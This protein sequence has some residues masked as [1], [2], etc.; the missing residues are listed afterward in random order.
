[1]QALP[2]PWGLFPSLDKETTGELRKQFEKSSFSQAA[3]WIKACLGFHQETC[4]GISE[5]SLPTRVLDVGE[6]SID[7]R[8]VETN[9]RFG[10]YTSLSHCWGGKQPLTTTRDNFQKHLVSIPWETIPTTFQE[11]IKFNWYLGIQYL[12]IDSLCII[13]Q[14]SE[15]WARESAK[16]CQV[17]E[18]SYVTIAASSAFNSTQGLFLQDTWDLLS[19]QIS[20]A[21]AQDVEFFGRR[22]SPDHPRMQTAPGQEG[23]E[24]WP[25]FERAWVLQER[26]MSPRVV[27]FFKH[28]VAWECGR[29]TLCQCS[30]IRPTGKSEYRQT[31]LQSSS[32]AICAQWRQLVEIYSC[33]KLSFLSD[34]LPALSGLAKQMTRKRPG[35]RYLAGVWSDSLEMDLLWTRWR[36]P[37]MLSGIDGASAIRRAPSWSWVAIDARVNFLNESTVRLKWVYSRILDITT[38]LETADP[39]GRVSGGELTISGQFFDA[40]VCHRTISAERRV[41]DLPLETVEFGL[42]IAGT[43]KTVWEVSEDH[44]NEDALFFDFAMDPF[45]CG[46]GFVQPVESV[47]ILRMARIRHWSDGYQIPRGYGNLVQVDEA[48]YALILQRVETTETYRRV[49]ML[50]QRRVRRI[51]EA[52]YI[53]GDVGLWQD[54]PNAFEGL[55]IWDTVKIV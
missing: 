26:L 24:D 15:D 36:R 23:N 49:G 37:S 1:M 27:H 53:D 54:Y 5:T 48:E 47:K 2:C 7:I 8:L 51:P 4:P 45:G 19:L 52:K 31:P 17:Y 43:G 55:G 14:D 32:P 3:E 50:I 22:A 42:T 29:G 21:G 30:D 40:T 18:N 20:R 28:E 46:R 41:P 16:M 38:T 9:G 39:T 44:Q 33:L 6:T 13:Q 35:A 12:W 34:K 25:L 10:R 11:A